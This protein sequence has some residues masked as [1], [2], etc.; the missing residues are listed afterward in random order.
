M[1]NTVRT[2]SN[3]CAKSG[4][5]SQPLVTGRAM[6]RDRLLR[7]IREMR[8]S[9][10]ARYRRAMTGDELCILEL[11]EKLARSMPDLPVTSL[12]LEWMPEPDQHFDELR[13]L[14]TEQPLGISQPQ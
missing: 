1:T 10:A 6:S 3:V 4:I 7:N 12:Q 13:L 8:L 9:F 5:L 11:A 14:T 2:V